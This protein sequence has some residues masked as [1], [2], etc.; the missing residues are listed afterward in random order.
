MM[1]Q[2]HSTHGRGSSA[3][4]HMVFTNDD[5]LTEILIRLPILCIHLFITV[6]KQWL[7][8][9]TSPDFTDRRRKIPNL[10]PPAGIFANHRKRLFKCEFVSL[11]PILESRKSAMDNSLTLGFNEEADHVKIL[12]SC[13]GS[14]LCSGSGSSTFYYAY[15]PSTNLFKRL[16][17]PENS[18]D[19]SILHATGVFRMAFD[20][21]KS[22][23]YK[24]LTLYKFYIDDHDHPIITILEIPNGLHQG[25][26]F[27]QS[28]VDDDIDSRE[29]TIYEMMKGC[30]MWTVR[31]DIGSSEFT[32]YEMM[33]GSSMWSRREGDA[34]VVIN[35]S[36]K[37]IK[38]NLISKTNN[39]IFDIGFNQTDDD[40]DD[41]VEFVPPFSVHPNLYEFIL[42]RASV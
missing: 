9:L 1:S 21:T 25:R 27:L 7:Q 11:D 26:N 23:D 24:V 5:L 28:F 38:Y 10:D 36:G 13:N 41:D 8:I 40:D 15:N 34:F 32:I 14:L 20:P 19:D 17:Q 35:L 22:C 29:F 30:S 37:V 39:E 18:H 2:S 6:S 33:K 16:P 4:P 12:Q 31:D 3:Q 42:S